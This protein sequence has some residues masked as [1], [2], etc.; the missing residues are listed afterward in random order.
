MLFRSPYGSE[1][2]G[3]IRHAPYLRVY[4]ND[5]TSVAAG[6][7]NR[8]VTYHKI[9]PM[10]VAIAPGDKTYCCTDLRQWTAHPGAQ[11]VPTDLRRAGANTTANKIAVPMGSDIG[12]IGQG[13]GALNMIT[14]PGGIPYRAIAASPAYWVAGSSLSATKNFV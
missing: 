5:T 13:G 14:I 1:Y 7:G 6:I 3:S 4:G 12:V 2:E 11:N 8:A 9:G 10:F